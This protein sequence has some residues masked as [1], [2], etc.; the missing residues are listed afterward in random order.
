M[1]SPLLYALRPIVHPLFYWQYTTMD[2]INKSIDGLMETYGSC[3]MVNHSGEASLPGRESIAR[4][5]HGLD[6][7]IFPGF[8]ENHGLDHNNLR[9]IT[10]EKV[11]HLAR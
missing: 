3:G 6:E 10:A 11:N 2:R 7:L 9:L 5:V 4:I 1:G 8:R